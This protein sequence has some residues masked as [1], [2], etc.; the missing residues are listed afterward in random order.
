M[1]VVVESVSMAWHNCVMICCTTLRFPVQCLSVGHSVY[2]MIQRMGLLSHF[3]LDFVHSRRKD[4][5]HDCKVHGA[6]MGPIWGRQDPGGP[7]VG[8]G[9]FAI[10]VKSLW[11]HDMET[12]SASLVICENNPLVISEALIFPLLIALYTM[13]NKLSSCRRFETAL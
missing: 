13:L 9:N 12:L 10:W 5:S 6:N 8:P 7:H 1:G 2:S 4:V 3:T 11:L